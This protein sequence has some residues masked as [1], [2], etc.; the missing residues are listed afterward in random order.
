MLCAPSSPLTPTV[1]VVDDDC[2]VRDS[3]ERLIGHG[4]WRAETFGSGREFLAR[5]R[6][7]G[8]SCLIL[9]VY[10][11]DI[12]GLELQKRLIADHAEVPVIVISGY[13]D[14]PIAVEAMKA[15]AVEFLTK[16]FASAVV[17]RAIRE[18]I[19]HSRAALER[20]KGIHALRERQASLTRREREVME[21][22]VAGRLNKEVGFTL[23]ISE[24]TVKAHRG[25]VMRKMHADSLAALVKMNAIDIEGAAPAVA[26][27]RYDS[28]TDRSLT[29]T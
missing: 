19:E 12:S 21:L 27:P 26:G 5:V 18:A 9:D 3:L 29:L 22:V 25:N 7:S 6:P 10:L 1:Y 23:G 28:G 4:G 17:L 11:P 8:P 24:I 20:E 15:G 16:P 13:A 14:V 2:D